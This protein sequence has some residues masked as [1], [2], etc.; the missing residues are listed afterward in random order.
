[1]FY[2]KIKIMSSTDFIKTPHIAIFCGIMGSGKTKLALDLIE[3]YYLNHYD[4]I[5]ILCST[6]RHNRTYLDRGWIK[7]DQYVWVIEPE[8]TSE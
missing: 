5:I 3:N 4:Y 2:F 7:T 6:L 1:M 8:R